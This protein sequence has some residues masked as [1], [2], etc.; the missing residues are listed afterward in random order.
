MDIII[1][2]LESILG[3][4]ARSTSFA[5]LR[6]YTRRIG[7]TKQPYIVTGQNTAHRNATLSYNYRRNYFSRNSNSPFAGPH[8]WNDLSNKLRSTTNAVTLKNIS[9]LTF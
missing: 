5:G 3:H 9:R 6:V 1:E 4:T 2:I 8:A 7:K